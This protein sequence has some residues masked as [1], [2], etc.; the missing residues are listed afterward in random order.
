MTRVGDKLHVKVVDCDF[1][2]AITKTTSQFAPKTTAQ[3]LETTTNEISITLD[4]V[5][6]QY[7]RINLRGNEYSIEKS[8]AKTLSNMEDGCTYKLIS[9]NGKLIMDKSSDFY[10]NGYLIT[11]ENGKLILMD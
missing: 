4:P 5:Y 9:K 3:A 11:K 1:Q 7:K 6:P 2:V 8:L 10:S